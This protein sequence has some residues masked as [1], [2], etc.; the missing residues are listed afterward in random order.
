MGDFF[1]RITL[2]VGVIVTRIDA[3]LVADPM[4]MHALD[5][6]HHWVAHVHVRVGHVDFGAQ[7]LLAIGKLTGAH[8]FKQIE[9]LR[10]RPL[11]IW[12]GLTGLG[13]RTAVLAHLVEG[14]LLDIGMPRFDQLQRPFKQ[15]LEIITGKANLRPLKPQPCDVLLDRTNELVAL[16]LGIGI[17]E[18]QVAL[19][20][21]LL[22]DAEIEANRFGVADL[23][24]TIWLGRE[25]CLHTSIVLTSC[26]VGSHHLANKIG[27]RF[28]SV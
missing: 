8:T 15:L 1:E 18:A 11:T 6:I 25:A 26:H 12:A 17:V 19:T 27:R 3:P 10:D 5:T 16:L 7:H 24:I 20:A 21:K 13:N 9:A 2:T 22:G 14:Q 4:V 28:F 23:Q